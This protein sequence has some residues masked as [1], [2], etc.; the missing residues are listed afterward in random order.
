MW[1][2]KKKTPF[3]ALETNEQFLLFFSKLGKMDKASFA[4]TL[5]KY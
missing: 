4:S 1:K 3:P 2:K 5:L